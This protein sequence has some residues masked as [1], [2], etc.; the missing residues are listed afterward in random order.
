MI[1]DI[2]I[3]RNFGLSGLRKIL[4]LPQLVILLLSSCVLR[5]FVHFATLSE[6]RNFVRH[7]K[8]LKAAWEYRIYNTEHHSSG[9]RA[10]KKIKNF[11]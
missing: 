9:D 5:F 3:F 2:Y 6:I 11:P 4:I 1:N 7:L 8:E 10:N